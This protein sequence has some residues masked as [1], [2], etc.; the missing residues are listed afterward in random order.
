MLCIAFLNVGL[1]VSSSSPCSWPSMVFVFF[2]T[3]PVDFKTKLRPFLFDQLAARATTSASF[4]ITKLAKV[5]GWAPTP[6][7]TRLAHFVG[8]FLFCNLFV[9]LACSWWCSSPRMTGAQHFQTS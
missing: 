9:F 6:T 4:V 5:R 8:A 3:V 7:S 2:Q 1:F